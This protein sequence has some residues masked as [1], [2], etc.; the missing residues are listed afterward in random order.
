MRASR[1]LWGVWGDSDFDT[2]R[3][4][5][6]RRSDKL[7]AWTNPITS[8]AAGDGRS[9]FRRRLSPDLSY[10]GN[11]V[12]KKGDRVSPTGTECAPSGRPVS[13]RFPPSK[14]M[15]ADDANLAARARPVSRRAVRSSGGRRALPGTWWAM[16][17]LARR[18]KEL[19][20][21]LRAWGSPTTARLV[22]AAHALARRTACAKATCRCLPATCSWPAAT[23]ARQAALSTN[24]VSKLA[25]GGRSGRPGARSAANSAADRAGRAADGRSPHRAGPRRAGAIAARWLGS[26]A[27][28]SSGGART[29][30]VVAVEF[31]QQG[32]SV[33]LEDFQVEPL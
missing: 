26:K 5:G 13:N 12:R 27:R 15:P 25:D 31:L 17:T 32:A 19:M 8:W 4:T 1:P 33:L 11:T 30:L 6:P 7:K 18:E 10:G 29:W 3:K 16:Y 20:R 23:R 21:R 2:P 24:C 9:G 14:R 28:S 22:H